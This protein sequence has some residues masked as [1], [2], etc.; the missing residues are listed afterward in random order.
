[1]WIDWPGD[2][3]GLPWLQSRV[4]VSV[5]VGWYLLWTRSDF[6]KDCP[7]SP[8]LFHSPFSHLLYHF[9]WN[10]YHFISGKKTDWPPSNV[11]SVDLTSF[12][13][14]HGHPQPSNLESLVLCYETLGLEGKHIALDSDHLGTQSGTFSQGGT[15]LAV[16]LYPGHIRT[17][18]WSSGSMDWWLLMRWICGVAD[19]G[20]RHSRVIHSPPSCHT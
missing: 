1:M 4:Q 9:I 19:W 12:R 3:A 14:L 7:I 16:A 18:L 6:S 17:H 5:S 8:I 20:L 10:I 15:E 13:E 11:E 2:S